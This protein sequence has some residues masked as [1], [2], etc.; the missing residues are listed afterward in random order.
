MAGRACR[1]AKMT[2]R[3]NR[4]GRGPGEICLRVP[5]HR[6]HGRLAKALKEYGIT[7][8]RIA[9]DDMRIAM[10]LQQIGMDGITFVPGEQIFRKIRVVKTEPELALQRIGGRNNVEAGDGRV[11]KACA[12]G[13][14][15]GE[16]E[17]RF[18]TECANRGSE[19]MEFLVGTVQGHF[20]DRVVTEGKAFSVDAVS[21]L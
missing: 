10:L 11:A 1:G 8:G 7:K 9:V 5:S 21:S 2:D 3:A 6:L 13:M 16:I 18:L 12:K 20:P 14:T 19:V 4:R 17:H 15:Y